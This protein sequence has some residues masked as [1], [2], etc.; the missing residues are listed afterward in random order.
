[1]SGSRETRRL[2]A[3]VRTLRQ[4]EHAVAR[5]LVETGRPVEAYPAIL[6]AIGGALGWR[7]GAVWELE[8]DGLL[9]CVRTWHADTRVDEFET[10][11]ATLALAPGIGLPGRVLAAGEPVWMT[12]APDDVNFPR[13]EAARRSGLHAAFAFPVRGPHGVV[14]VIEFFS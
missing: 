11:S 4:V 3:D 9:R 6:S 7:L 5:I 1:M 14:G 2:S 13:A 10:L 12:D 8:P